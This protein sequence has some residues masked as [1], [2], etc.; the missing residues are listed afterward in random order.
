MVF[1]NAA[2]R[3]PGVVIAQR[4]VQSEDPGFQERLDEGQDALHHGAEI[5]LLRDLYA[6][7]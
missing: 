5:A 2:L 4:P 7:R 6:S 3:H 1:Q